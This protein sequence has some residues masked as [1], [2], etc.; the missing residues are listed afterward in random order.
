MIF[1]IISIGIL[2]IGIYT[3]YKAYTL[4][5]SYLEDYNI[6][7]SKKEEVQKAR[8]DLLMEVADLVD[9]INEKQQE[10]QNKMQSEKRLLEEQLKIYKE[11]TSYAAEQYVY[12]IEQHYDKVENDCRRELNQLTA[13]KYRVEAEVKKMSDALSAGVAAQLREREK[14]E[15]IDFYKLK[16]NES[17]LTDILT[18][19]NIKHTL[20]QPVVLSKL[21]WSTYFQKQTTELCNRILSTKTICGIYKITN[22]KTKQCYIGQSKDVSRRWKNHIKCGLGIDAPITNKLYNA[23]QKDGVWNFTF[24][25]MEECPPDQLNEKERFWIDMYQSDKYSYNG[26]KGNS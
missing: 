18:L 5:R 16:L 26:T 15:N 1:L 2:L 7:K 4:D 6:V 23:M 9:K 14:E 13:E 20:R 17:E 21:I 25:L 8:D 10:L 24:E 12:A 19:N 11:N 3:L 22:L